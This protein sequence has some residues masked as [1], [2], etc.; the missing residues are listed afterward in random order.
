[1]EW[2]ELENA[3][4]CRIRSGAV[5][6]LGHKF[7]ED[8]LKDAFVLLKR[9]LVNALKKKKANLKVNVELSADF[10]LLRSG[11][12]EAKYFATP[13]LPITPTTNLDEVMQSFQEIVLNKVRYINISF[14]FF[15]G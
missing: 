12:I 3:F 10:E 2:L 5:V 7:A 14:F 1:M 13:N 6:N 11:V 15:I 4:Q 9:R 8:F